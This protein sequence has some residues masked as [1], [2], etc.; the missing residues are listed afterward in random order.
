MNPSRMTKAELIEMVHGLQFSLEEAHK[1]IRYFSMD[2]P[3]FQKAREAETHIRNTASKQLSLTQ[4]IE[5]YD[6]FNLYD[7]IVAAG[8]FDGYEDAVAKQDAFNTVAQVLDDECV[9][10][11]KQTLTKYFPD[12]REKQVHEK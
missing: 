6:L 7:S 1:V 9:T 4:E 5:K 2:I 11:K 12:R 10:F 3:A 8:I